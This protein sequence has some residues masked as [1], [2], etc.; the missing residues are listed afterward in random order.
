MNP[1]NFTATQAAFLHCEW[2]S[3]ENPSPIDF[4]D[5]LWATNYTRLAAATL[6]VLFFAGRDFAPKCIIDGKNIQDYLQD[7][8]FNAIAEL[9][10][11]IRDSKDKLF[12]DCVIG[13]DSFN[14]PN[15]TYLSLE[16]LNVIPNHWQLKKGE[17]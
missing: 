15:Q 16:D 10:K 13:W 3:A 5:M 6:S 11:K 2:P 12:E 8:Y 4:P 14:E 1:R 7:H 9:A 17:Y